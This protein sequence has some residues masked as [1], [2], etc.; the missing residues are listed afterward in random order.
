VKPLAL[1]AVAIGLVA[2]GHH[3]NGE[4]FVNFVSFGGKTAQLS[5]AAACPGTYGQ[6]RR[7]G[8]GLS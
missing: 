8:W 3:L 2:Y 1:A 6:I 4:L 5:A 7:G